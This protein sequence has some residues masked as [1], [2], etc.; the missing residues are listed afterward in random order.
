MMWPFYIIHPLPLQAPL[1]LRAPLRNRHPMFRQRFAP[2]S[3]PMPGHRRR[4]FRNG[5]SSFFGGR[6][7]MTGFRQGVRRASGFMFRRGRSHSGGFGPRRLFQRRVSGRQRRQ[8]AYCAVPGYKLVKPLNTGGMS[9]AVNLVKNSRSGK[10]F[11]EK[12]IRVTESRQKRT[13]AELRALQ[14]MRGPNLNKMVEHKWSGINCSFV[15]EYCNAGS[16]EDKVEDLCRRR[17]MISGSYAK[18]ILLSVAK[19]LSFLHHGMLDEYAHGV[20]NWDAIYHL[21]IKPQNILLSNDQRG[22]SHPRVV[23]ADFGCAISEIDKRIGRES[24]TTPA[25]G[26][27]DYYPPEGLSC[28]VGRGRT[29]YGSQTD[30]FMLGATIHCLCRKVTGPPK[31]NELNSPIPCGKKYSDLLNSA[32]AACSR[33]NWRD[34]IS[35]PELVRCLT[36]CRR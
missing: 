21:D 8:S 26:T 34:R 23:L 25:A 10:L 2:M 31:R 28:I 35:A 11:V 3:G 16:L 36:K 4:S 32:V 29:R 15:L 20:P 17:S 12:R 13:A 22:L 33:Y 5:M 24:T 14:K 27:P 7:G 6:R 9:D 1:P 30:L 19:A 18:H